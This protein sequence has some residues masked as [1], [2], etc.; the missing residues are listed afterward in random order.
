MPTMCSHPVPHHRRWY[1]GA[2]QLSQLKENGDS[3]T[4]GT[5]LS[6]PQ[7]S[8]DVKLEAKDPE[9]PGTTEH[10]CDDDGTHG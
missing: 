1:D 3:A 8:V 6:A 5:D 4:R 2:T 10:A 9:N 7:Q